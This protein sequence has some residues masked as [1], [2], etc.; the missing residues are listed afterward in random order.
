MQTTTQPKLLVALVLIGPMLV[1]CRSVGALF[2]KENDPNETSVAGSQ[3]SASHVRLS[4][5]NFGSHEN[6]DYLGPRV[7]TEVGNLFSDATPPSSNSLIE[8]VSIAQQQQ[9]QQ[10]TPASFDDAIDGTAQAA[11]NPARPSQAS[12]GTDGTKAQQAL[13]PAT[14]SDA[15]ST[16]KLVSQLVISGV[17]PGRG[18]VK[19]AIF[20]DTKTFPQPDGAS[21]VFNLNPDRAQLELPINAEP[22]FAVAVYQDINGDGVLSRNRLGIPLEPFAFSNNAM[23]KRGPPTFDEAKIEIP[24]P[25]AMTTLIPIKLP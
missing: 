15:H 2:L 1:G 21:Q 6:M 10:P 25:T 9:Q 24:H 23:G 3:V 14:F 16:D 12:V 4:T 13:P 17:R 20:T 22:P 5:T 18:K 19:I 7:D 11:A 8:T